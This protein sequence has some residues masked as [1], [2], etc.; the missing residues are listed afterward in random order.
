MSLKQLGSVGLWLGPRESEFGAVAAPQ[1]GLCTEGLEAQLKAA[2]VETLQAW[3][4]G[5]PQT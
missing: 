3:V 2:P 5:Q 1:K 4:R